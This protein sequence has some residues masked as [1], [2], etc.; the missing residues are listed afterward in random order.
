[1]DADLNVKL[2]D[3]GESVSTRVDNTKC[4]KSTGNV[5]DRMCKKNEKFY[6]PTKYYGGLKCSKV[7]ASSCWIFCFVCPWIYLVEMD[8]VVRLGD[9]AHRR[10]HISSIHTERRDVGRMDGYRS[11][12]YVRVRQLSLESKIFALPLRD[13]WSRSAIQY[14]TKVKV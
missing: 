13:G 4:T 3:F 10:R 5:R 14:P 11:P 8:I 6:K 12:V 2:S 7:Y 1:M 9:R